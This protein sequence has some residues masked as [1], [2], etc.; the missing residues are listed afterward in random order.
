MK[1]ESMCFQTI[2]TKNWFDSINHLIIDVFVIIVN[3]A[4]FDCDWFDVD[5]HFHE[6]KNDFLNSFSFECNRRVYVVDI[7]TIM[8]EL[9][10][11]YDWM[12]F[13]KI[14]KMFKCNNNFSIA[15][16]IDTFIFCTTK[17]FFTH[18]IREIDYD[19]SILNSFFQIVSRDEHHVLMQFFMILF[20][21]FHILS[22]KKFRRKIVATDSI[23]HDEK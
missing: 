5:I 1:D 12:K 15:I 16:E 11:N 17:I 13:Q 3:D 22:D 8:I 14:Y 19:W 23:E 20:K 2:D 21:N 4:F 7:E 9:N 10:E 18:F 6:F